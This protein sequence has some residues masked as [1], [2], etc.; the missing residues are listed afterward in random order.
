MANDGAGTGAAG[1]V[2]LGAITNG[3]AV[4]NDDTIQLTA[5]SP[6]ISAGSLTLV[7]PSS[8]DPIMV[9]AVDASEE[10]DKSGGGGG[11]DFWLCGF[12]FVA[13]KRGLT[14]RAK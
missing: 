5:N 2:T 9:M 10:T 12:M 7:Q 6:Y 13:C 1:Q 11:F 4:L 3:S 14:N 8:Y